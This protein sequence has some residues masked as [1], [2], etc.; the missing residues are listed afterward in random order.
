VV[1]AQQRLQPHAVAFKGDRGGVDHFDGRSAGLPGWLLIRARVGH[2]VPCRDEQ[3][4]DVVRGE[5]AGSAP[6]QR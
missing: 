6:A 2:G 3:G 5:G 1:L 4:A